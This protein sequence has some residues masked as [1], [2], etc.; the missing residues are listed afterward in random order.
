[1]KFAFL[2]PVKAEPHGRLISPAEPHARM[3][4]INQNMVRGSI[5]WLVRLSRMLYVGSGYKINYFV[6]SYRALVLYIYITI[7]LQLATK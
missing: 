1:M 3:Q 7:T 4:Q 6:V 2:I 5:N